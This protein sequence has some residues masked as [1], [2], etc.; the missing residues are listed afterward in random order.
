VDVEPGLF[1][2]ACI[3]AHGLQLDV[4][5]LNTVGWAGESPSWPAMFD[6]AAVAE[7]ELAASPWAAPRSTLSC[8][9]WRSRSP[10]GSPP[11]STV[12]PPLR[13]PILGGALA[14]GKS[15]TMPGEMTS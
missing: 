6:R 8:A 10:L 12:R 9:P 3:V 14:L 4:V 13:S 1:A 2:R 7:V 11:R 15:K 5:A